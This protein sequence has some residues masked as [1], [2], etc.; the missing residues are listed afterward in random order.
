MEYYDY[1]SDLEGVGVLMKIT[2]K[3]EKKKHFIT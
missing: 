1:F 2:L 3:W